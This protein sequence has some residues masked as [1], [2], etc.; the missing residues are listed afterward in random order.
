MRWSQLF[1]P[2]LREEPANVEAASHRLLVRAGYIRP[3][4]SGVYSL[5]PLAQRVR[6]KIIEIIRDEMSKIGA[7]EFMLSAL[8]PLE[9]WQESGR[10]EA[11]SDVMFRLKDRKQA[12]L[13]LGLTHEEVFT[14]IARAGLLSYKQL[15]QMWYQ[16]QTKFRD[17]LRPK[18]GLLRVREFTMKDSYSFDIDT[19]GLDKSFQLH[20]D[21][22]L[23]IFKRCGLSFRAVEASS[24]AMGGSKSVE[25]MVLTPAGED[26]LVLCPGCE[27]AANLERAE[28]K[29]PECN[30]QQAEDSLQ[31]FATPGVKTIRDLEVFPGGAAASS[32]IKTLIYS[33]DEKLAIAL[34]QGDQELNEAKLQA[35]L[36]ASVLRQATDQEIV[37]A[38]GAHP[39]SLGA[40][41]VASGEG[42]KISRILA[43]PRLRSR[44]NMVTGANKD[45]FHLRNVSVDRDMKIDTWVDLHSVQA[46]ESCIKCGGT[47]ELTKGL[48]IGHIFKLGTRYSESMNAGVLGPEGNNHPL[49]MGSYGIGVERLMASIAETSHDDYGL[50][51]PA[52][53]APFQVVVVVVNSQDQRLVEA[54]DQICKQLSELGI[55]YILDDRNERPGVKFNDADLVGIP[56]RITV[57]K[58]VESGQVELK[59]RGSKVASDVVLADAARVCKEKL[60]L[61]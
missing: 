26:T 36:G 27:Y 13:A 59:E 23:Q 2:T 30:G 42:K 21:A 39:G 29:T 8:Q 47:L 54:A 7:Q 38:M 18:G 44:K 16:I 48:E 31:E 56:L 15:P 20:H 51:W 5:L 53:V 24:G 37:D 25:F 4:A 14:S 11:V 10:L 34:V 3:L 28:C 46:G 33:A 61:K 40:C 45:G 49:V 43:D 6:L 52:A 12:E 60:A 19:D 35:A 1:I 41:G 57:G 9:L 22:Y 32:Q 58:K 17:E 50:I 55:E